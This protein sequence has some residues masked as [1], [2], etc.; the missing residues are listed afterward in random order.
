MAK[1]KKCKPV[2]DWVQLPLIDESQRDLEV[3][4]ETLRLRELDSFKDY[5]PR[6]GR[7]PG[8]PMPPRAEEL[9]RWRADGSID[10]LYAALSARSMQNPAPLTR[11]Q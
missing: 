6:A 10:R 3:L 5:L 11:A 7:C 9:E 8:N 4:V 2:P 1:R